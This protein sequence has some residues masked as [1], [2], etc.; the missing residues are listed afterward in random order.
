[1]SKV[2]KMG[3]HYFITTENLEKATELFDFAVKVVELEEQLGAGPLAIGKSYFEVIGFHHRIDK[4]FLKKI[5]VE[6][7]LNHFREGFD[8]W[9]SSLERGS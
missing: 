9:R 8:D 7:E 2:E 3:S 4:W 6:A 1:M 5:D